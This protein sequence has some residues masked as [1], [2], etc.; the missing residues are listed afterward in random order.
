MVETLQRWVALA[1]ERLDG[2]GV[3]LF[4]MPGNDDELY[5][6]EHLT[7]RHVHNCDGRRITVGEYELY[8]LSW[9]TPT[10]W[11][12]PREASEDDLWA[13]IVELTG[14]TSDFQRAIF[15]FHV[16]PYDSGLD[17]G[18]ALTDDLEVVQ[19]AG[20]PKQVPIGS[21]SVRRAIEEL[22]PLLALHGH[23]HESRAISS[24]GRTVC[25]N[26][27]SRYAEGVV[28]GAIVTLEGP[29]VSARQLVTG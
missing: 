23:V 4:V 27:G 8:S 29:R 25:I 19:E 2:S 14:G 7:G 9:S 6:D 24:I 5:L 26:P 21:R 3:E 16:P 15:N 22:Q 18:P 13:R 20:Q 10:P 12:T 17:L 11:D 1:E 28:D